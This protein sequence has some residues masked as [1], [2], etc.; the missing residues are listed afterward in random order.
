MRIGYIPRHFGPGYYERRYALRSPLANGLKNRTLHVLSHLRRKLYFSPVDGFFEEALH[1]AGH[2]TPRSHRDPSALARSRADALV[3]HF[4]AASDRLR[5][6]D[7]ALIAIARAFP[8]VKALFIDADEAAVM[9]DDRVLDCYDVVFKR[10]PFKDLGRYAIATRNRDKIRPTMLSCPY[11]R[12]S[13][14]R[15]LSHRR[16]GK[17]LGAEGGPVD[18]DVF[19]IGKATDARLAAWSALAAIPDIRRAGGLLPRI[20]FDNDRV[21]MTSPLDVPAFISRLKSSRINLAVDGH[22]EFTFRHLETW[23]AGGFLLASPSIRHIS[24]PIDVREGEHF[25]CYDD[26][27][28]LRDKVIHYAGQPERCRE[29]AANGKR[30]FDAQYDTDRHGRDI[31]SALGG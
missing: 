30:L 21:L 24:L 17:A 26:L 9:K 10:E 1:R 5:G 20:G 13:P 31:L 11:F 29:I 18:A 7:D 6:E 4:R 15:S 19:F 25:E 8:G 12:H 27:D 28:D 3:V 16:H 23:C 14:Y 2:V 22:G